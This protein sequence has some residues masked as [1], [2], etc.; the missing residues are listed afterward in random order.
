MD[1]QRRGLGGSIE[2]GVHFFLFSLFLYETIEDLW[3][4]WLGASLTESFLI[5]LWTSAVNSVF[6][7]NT[8]TFIDVHNAF[9]SFLLQKLQAYRITKGHRQPRQGQ[10][11]KSVIA[12]DLN[13]AYDRSP[14]LYAANLRVTIPNIENN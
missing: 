14:R 8:D 11:P 12:V 4:L 10:D 13:F 5:L 1:R 6:A 9:G 7:E 3:N 2:L